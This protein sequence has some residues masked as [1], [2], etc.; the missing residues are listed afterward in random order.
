VLK[1][2]KNPKNAFSPWTIARSLVEGHW[3]GSDNYLLEHLPYVMP[4]TDNIIS[5]RDGE[6]LGSV[7]LHGISAETAHSDDIDLQAANFARLVDQS[8]GAVTFYVNKVTSYNDVEGDV[9][10][11]NDFASFVDKKWRGQFEDRQAL[12]R[13]SLITIG[14]RNTA[15]ENLMSAF[16]K[17]KNTGDV[18]AKL[19][20]ILD[21]LLREVVS[22]LGKAGARRLTLSSGE[23]LG[24]LS[25]INTGLYHPIQ[26]TGMGLPIA[27]QLPESDIL[28]ARNKFT[29]SGA[30]DHERSVGAV[31]SIKKYPSET[32]AG[33]FDSLDMPM[34]VVVSHSFTP[35]PLNVAME[36]VKL[37]SRQMK[38]SED[39]AQ[40]LADEL[41]FAKDGLASGKI[42]LGRHH[43]SVVVH[44]E[45]E[46][47]LDDAVG[48][49]KRACGG[50]GGTLHREGLAMRSVFFGQHP[51]NQAYRARSGFVTSH[52]F[53][54]MVAFHNR[55]SGKSG[56]VPWGS[57]VTQFLTSNNDVFNFN[58]HKGQQSDNELTSGHTLVCGHTGSGKSV[59]A[60]F[61]M[62]QVQ[63]FGTRIVCFDKDHG[64]EIPLRALGIAY[65]D[66]KI[67]QSTGLNPFRSE[68]DQ[69]GTS[70]LATWVESLISAHNPITSTQRNA[71]ANAAKENSRAASDDGELNTFAEFVSFFKSLEDNGDLSD[72]LQEWVTGRFSWMFDGT[73]ADPLADSNQSV[74]FDV[75]EL[76]D[77]PQMRSAWLSYIFRRIERMVEDGKPTMIVM[78][79]AWKLLDDPM[80]AK[81]LKDWLLVMRKK[82]AMVLMLTQLPEHITE[83]AAGDAII[84]GT[85]TKIIFQNPKAVVENFVKLGLTD[86]E[87]AMIKADYERRSVLCI[88]DDDSL[89]LDVDLSPLGGALDVLSGSKSVRRSLADDWE[90]NPEF[91]KGIVE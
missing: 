32:V 22:S 3:A 33:M 73:G 52:N 86:A 48:Y 65:G 61:L 37:V 16:Q 78:D 9:M 15:S 69:R 64:L 55:P 2:K 43:C 91:W 25:S 70:W 60:A 46:E 81:M 27:A 80:F 34:R 57:P 90:N 87:A 68:T 45:N 13:Y 24:Y 20:G 8:Q 63:R 66:V 58:F 19:V 38:A 76:F 49:M 82:N 12:R 10:S 30:Y 11:G 50:A 36:K 39:D 28:F 89:L 26:P 71:I 17:S 54:D 75:T 42:A 4:V 29:I 23:L 47:T 84:S 5:T 62:A 6:L 14:I 67:G 79:E 77:E 18:R 56:G 51:G 7:V 59:L 44:A 72:R 35:V 88:S 21:T 53:A 85:P 41:E 31:M 40:S 83:S 1:F 74:A